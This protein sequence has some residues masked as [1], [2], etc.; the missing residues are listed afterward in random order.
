MNKTI[1]ILILVALTIW[2]L[3]TFFKNLDNPNNWRLYAS[4]GGLILFNLLLGLVV[5][6]V[7]QKK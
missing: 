1:S 4:L 2:S 6:G 3:F 7:Y 5:R